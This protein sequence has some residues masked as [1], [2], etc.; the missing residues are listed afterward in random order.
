MAANFEIVEQKR[1]IDS[2]TIPGTL[3]PAMDVTFRTI[4]T[5][6]VSTV[7]VPLSQY[8]PE[9]VAEVV[10]AEAATIETVNAL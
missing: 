10:G 5:G 8:T 9:H 4:P 3:T 7:R 6:T 2:T 1:V